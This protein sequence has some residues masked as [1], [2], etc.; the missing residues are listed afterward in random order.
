MA[1]PTTG[2]VHVN[3]PLTNISIAYIQ[4]KDN[5]IADKVFPNVPV[6]KQSDRYFSYPKGNW[7]RTEAKV[8]APGT[9]SAGSGWTVDNTPTYF[10]PIIAVHKD[11]DDQ[12]RNNA[13]PAIDMD[14]DATEFVTQ[15]CLLK[16][17]LDWK[18]RY[19]TTGL[20][21]AD[22]TPGTLWSAGGSTPIEDIQAQ[23][24]F[25][26]KNTGFKPN[27]LVL[28]AS[29]WYVLKNHAEF[30][31]RI[32]YTQTGMVSTGLLA[33]VLELDE[34]I[35]ANAV[36]NTAV[37]NATDALDFIFGKSALLCYANPSPSLL[38]PSAGYTF[39]WTGYLGAGAA[40]NRM[41]RFRME[42]LASDRL[43]CEMAYDMKLVAADLGVF[44][45]NVI[46]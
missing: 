12:I 28:S 13:D 1:Q 3:A 21:S 20:W 4:K 14:R 10:A 27:K 8:R 43:E 31:D 30:L 46:A 5:F 2:D 32:K 16:R 25:I 24:S 37:E 45:S 22:V 26:H 6:Q 11:V 35:I 29:V 19:F 41:K 38:T 39:S 36:Q 23:I 17:D 7:F 18:T 9:E 44:F 33:A 15:Q 40:G 42:Q 34:V